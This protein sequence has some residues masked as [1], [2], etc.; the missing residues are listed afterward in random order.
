M[1]DRLKRFIRLKFRDAGRQFEEAKRA[2]REGRANSRR[3]GLPRDASGRARVVCRR[4]AE[5]RAVTVD[6]DGR[7]QCF[8]A[9]HPDCRGCA[10]DIREG[11]VETW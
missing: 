8:D 7:P 3:F 5:K 9:D 4:Y 6:A 11:V 10:E 1:D 2:Y